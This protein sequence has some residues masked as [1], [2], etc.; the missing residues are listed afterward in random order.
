MKTMKNT[1]ALMLLSGLAAAP[2]QAQLSPAPENARAYII[3]PADGETVPQR[4]TVKFGLQGMGIAPAGVQKPGTGHH[5]LLINGELPKLDEA[6]KSNVKHFGKG[7]TETVL[8]L[9]KGR[10]TLQLIL[11]DHRHI[12]HNPPVV[13]EP[14]TIYVE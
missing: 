1:L 2:A 4:F 5:H 7:Q 14:I 12:P 11:G 6:M 9:P 3:S 10:H 13:S 8:E